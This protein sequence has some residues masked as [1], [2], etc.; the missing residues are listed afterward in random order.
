MRK[1]LFL[2]ILAFSVF[3]CAKTP[4]Q[5]CYKQHPFVSLAGQV[6]RASVCMETLYPKISVISGEYFWT[7][8]DSISQEINRL[9]LEM[10]TS[11]AIIDTLTVLVYDK[12][13]IQFDP[14]QDDA[15]TV[16]PQ[17]VFKEKKGSCMGVSL[18][19]LLIAEKAS[20]PLYGV[21]LPGH[22]FVRFDNG[23]QQRNI[24]PNNR[25]I[26]H[27]DSYYIQSYA[28][29]Q[30]RLCTSLINLDFQKTASVFYYTLASICLHDQKEIEAVAL[31]RQSIYLWNDF[32]Q[33]WGNLAVVY[34]Q[35]GKNDSAS[36]AFA[37]ASTICPDME[38]LALN[39]GAFLVRNKRYDEAITSYRQ[40]L[41]QYPLDGE[42]LY[43][44]AFT[45]YSNKM[46]DSSMVY[47]DRIKGVDSTHPS[48][49]LQH[50][51]QQQQK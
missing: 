44:I 19:F 27:S 35:H 25:G 42:L 46:Y 41:K 2:L 17:V 30:R 24:E 49:Q 47:L 45:F 6:D 43:G 18:L 4:Q 8:V 23:K 51:I 15:A 31:L 32:E 26:E 1:K 5:S 12:W 10:R 33:A 39:Y 28:L 21:M 22:F 34:T 37:Q 38:K 9:P 29:D 7:A 48:F 11:T 40:G 13:L 3:H 50:M 36:T 14:Q 16:V 20:I